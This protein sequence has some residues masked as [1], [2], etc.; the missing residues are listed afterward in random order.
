M[1]IQHSS[2]LYDAIAKDP[3]HHENQVKALWKHYDTDNDG[4]IHGEEVGKF[5]KELLEHLMK[6]NNGE[7]TFFRVQIFPFLA[8]LFTP[9]ALLLNLVR[10]LSFSPAS[11]Q[12]T[13]L[14]RHIFPF[15]A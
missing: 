9:L 13:F 8:I 6:L 3:R 14:L 15:L 11:F 2:H 4:K 12:G 10:P 1:G 7:G 5:T